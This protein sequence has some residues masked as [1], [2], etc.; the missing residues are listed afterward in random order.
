MGGVCRVG[1]SLLSAR[2]LGANAA[3]FAALS[4]LVVGGFPG[5]DPAAALEVS[6]PAFG[7][8]AEPVDPGPKTAPDLGLRI[9][10]ATAAARV[11]AAESGEPVEVEAARTD[12]NTYFVNPDGTQTAE[13]STVP[14]RVRADDG[15]WLDVD[16]TL[17]AQPDGTVATTATPTEVVLSG[18]GADT[19]LV[20]IAE[21]GE[22][23]SLGWPQ[24]LP[25]PVLDGATATYAEVLPGVDL[26]VEADL[27]GFSQFL[28]VK[29]PEAAAN[30]ELAEIDF[31]LE[32]SP[33]LEATDDAGGLMINGPDG[34]PAFT[35]PAPRMWESAPEP[36][37]MTGR[38]A[39]TT[40]GAVEAVT[41]P[42]PPSAEVVDRGEGED[43]AVMPI[44]VVDD[45]LTI[46][47]DQELLT[48]PETVFPVVIDPSATRFHQYWHMVWSN[49]MKFY[50]SSSEDA[51]VGYDGWSDG[52][53]SRVFYAIDYR[54]LSRGPQIL[55]ANFAHRQIHS[56]NHSCDLTTYGPGVQLWFT[57][58]IR[59]TQGWPGPAMRTHVATATRAHGHEDYCNNPVRT[60]WN[61]T[62]IATTAAA[63]GWTAFTLGLKSADEADRDGW[64]RFENITN[65]SQTRY[66]V[67]TVNYNWPPEKPTNL[68]TTTP[69]TVCDAGTTRPW[70]NDSTPIV[71]ANITEPDGTQNVQMV[72]DHRR[73]VA[74]VPWSEAGRSSFRDPG[75]IGVAMPTLVDGSYQW[76]VTATDGVGWSGWSAQTCEFS[77]DTVRPNQ[78]PTIISAQYPEE[79][80]AGGIG[81][82][83]TFTFGANTVA[84]VASYRYSL[85]S[86]ALNKTATPATIGGSKG[87]NIAPTEFGPNVLYAQS[88]DRAG[89]VSAVATYTFMVG[90]SDPI[91]V[92]QMNE[93][94]GTTVADQTGGS[95]TLTGPGHWGLDWRGTANPASSSL[96][97]GPG[98][99]GI[100][101]KG[102]ASTANSVL[103]GDL[104][105]YAVTAW[106][107]YGGVSLT[108]TGTF[109]EHGGQ[110]AY[111]FRVGTTSG[112][113]TLSAAR[114][115][116]AAPAVTTITNPTAT[117]GNRSGWTHV[118]VVHN[119]EA[120]TLTLYVD[121][122]Q[123]ASATNYTST[124]AFG[125]PMRL[126]TA[127]DG[128]VDDVRVYP[129]PLDAQS[130]QRIMNDSQGA[131]DLPEDVEAPDFTRTAS[132]T[133][134]SISPGVISDGTIQT[135]VRPAPV[136]PGA[137]TATVRLA[138]TPVPVAGLPVTVAALDEDGAVEAGTDLRVR[139]LDQ[140][141]VQGTELDGLLMQVAPAVAGTELTGDVRVSVDYSDFQNLGADY[142]SR[143]A[144]YQITP[145]DPAADPITICDLTIVESANDTDADTVTAKV[146][147]DGG[148]WF[149]AA[150][151]P[152]GPSGDY[153]ATSLAP[154]STWSAGG[155]AGGF[156]WNYPLRVPPTAGGMNPEL[157]IG[158]SSASVDGRTSSTNNQTSWI[159]EGHSLDPGFIERR[160]AGCAD[161]MGSGANNT[162]KTG[163][164][165]WKTDTVHLTLN[166][167]STEVILD[168]DGE[169]WR[170][171]NDDGSRVEHLTGGANGDNNGEYWRITT[172]DGTQYYFGM[173]KRDA[174][175]TAPTWS[176]FVVPVAGN[177]VGEPC[178]ATAFADS[179]CQ[180]A[181]RWNLAY[182]VDTDGNTITYSYQREDNRYSQNLD[183]VS[184]KYTRGGYLRMIEYGERHGSAH[185]T[186]APAKVDF[187]VAE[188]CLA[189]TGCAEADLTEGNA[190]RWP[191]VP[192][193]QM[194][195]STSTCTT[196]TS[197]TFFS[198]MRLVAV[199]TAVL[200]GGAYTEVDRWDLE[201]QF[202]SPGDG[203]SPALW[204]GRITHTGLAGST[205][206]ELPG[207]VFHGTQDANRVDGIDNA[208]PFNK[209]RMR[210]IRNESGGRISVN[211]STPEC[212]PS[213]VPS[214]PESNT[215][216]CFPVYYTPEGDDEPE[217]HWFHKYL[218]TSVV[219]DDQ[220]DSGVAQETHYSYEGEPAWAYQDS[221]LIPEDK[222][223]WGDWRGY[224][225]VVTTAGA[226]ELNREPITTETLYM[227]GM[228]G[229]HLPSGSRDVDVEDSEGATIED[230]K[231]LAG[232][233][234]ESITYDGEQIVSKAIHDPYLSAATADDGEQTAHILETARTRTFTAIVPDG[235]WRTTDTVMTYD[236][237][238]L[239]TQKNDRGDTSTTDDDL[240]TRTTY[241]RNTSLHIIDKPSRLETVSV[242]CSA[243][244]SRPGDVVTDQRFGYDGGAVG[245]V[246]TRGNATLNEELDSWSSGPVYIPRIRTTFDG[247]GR[248]TS[249]TD[250]LDRTT[251]TAYTNVSA[252]LTQKITTTNAAGH[253]STTTM[254][255]Y[256]GTPV[257]VLDA[258]EKTTTLQYDPLGRLLKV[259]G[260]D[261]ATSQTP[262]TEYVYSVRN[263]GVSSVA[264]KTLLPSGAQAIG[265]ELYDGWGRTRQVQ[266]PSAS[267]NEPGRLITDTEYDSRGLVVQVD[268]PYYNTGAPVAARFSPTLT[269]PAST[270][271]TYDGAGRTVM[272]AFY[273]NNT[274]QWRTTTDYRG[275]HTRV[276]PPDGDTPTAVFQDARG[277]V[278]RLLQYRGGSASGANDQTQY[279]YDHAGRLTWVRDP[280]HNEWTYEYD[281][282]GRQVEKNDPDTGTTQL[283]YDDAGQ[284]LTTTDAEGR[285][286][287]HTYDLL[288]RKTSNRQGSVTG[289]V[290]AEW[291]YDTLEL[292]QLTSSSRREGSAVYTEAVTGYDNGYRP[293]GTRVTIPSAEGT[294]IDGSYTFT[295]TYNPDGSV[296]RTTL[297]AIG[298][299]PAET[300]QNHYEP[301]GAVDWMYGY[302]TYAVDT[303]WSPYGEILRRGQGQYGTASWQTNTYETGTRRL[304][305]SR[306]DREDQS[307]HSDMNYAYDDAGN[308]TRM[309]DTPRNGT[310]DIQCFEYDYLR[311][312]TKAFTATDNGCDTPDLAPATGTSVKYFQ[313]YAYDLTGNRTSLTR[314][315]QS[316]TGTPTE[317]TTAYT[318]PTAGSAQPHTMRSAVTGST[319]TAFTYDD[320]GNTLT[321]GSESYTWDVEGRMATTTTP[322]GQSSFTYTA[323]GDRLVRRDP[324]SVTIYLPGH[325]LEL[326]TA[327]NAVTARR[328]YSFAGETIAVRSPAGGLQDLYA[329]H[330]D[331]SDIAVDADGGTVKNKER[332]P[333]GNYRGS[334]AHIANWPTD[335]GFH[336]GI[337]DPSTGLIQMGARVYDPEFGRFLSVDPIIDNG[338]PQQMN[339]YAYAN[340]SPITYSD[341]TGLF[342]S[343]QTGSRAATVGGTVAKDPPTPNKQ[344]GQLL[345]SGHSD[346]GG[347]GGGGGNNE[348]DDDDDDDCGW[349]PR[350]HARNAA[351]AVGDAARWAGDKTKDAVIGTANYVKD[352]AGDIARFVYAVTLKDLIDSCYA[353]FSL[354]GCIFSAFTTFTPMGRVAQGVRMGVNAI[355]AVDNVVDTSRA[356]DKVRTAAAGACSFAGATLV[357]MADGTRKAIEDI[358]IGDE[359]IA[360]DPE[361]GEQAAK[362]V[363]KVWVHEDTLVDLEV[364]GTTI[365]TTEDHPFWNASEQEFQ[366]AAAIDQGDSVLTADGRLLTVGGVD[367]ESA[368]EDLAYNLTVTDIH[369]YHVGEDDVLVHNTNGP[370]CHVGTN[371]ADV[372]RLR[373]QLLNE[374]AASAFT[375]AGTLSEG[376]LASSR[377]IIPG[378]EL[379]RK[380]PTRRL[381]NE[382]TADGSD[383]ADW[384]KYSTRTYQSPSGDFQ[385]HFYRNRATGNVNYNSDYKSVFNESR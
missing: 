382:L 181:W 160:Y 130:V 243:T 97:F 172:T 126:G 230:Q 134:S 140:A 335:R 312:L 240:C 177:H 317:T 275:D 302:N 193:D 13:L 267:A 370:G 377:R 168:E 18:G 164:L 51:R 70:V 192:F 103:R 352:H 347:G 288:G 60:E 316:S 239:M 150:A 83:G 48:D 29:T 350:C 245:V 154:S 304:L 169:T 139:G 59:S 16:T 255:T 144:L 104:P 264:T 365:T 246:P 158:Y 307:V 284:L 142:G 381:I 248:P 43:T 362:A 23:M 223:T 311:R 120:D 39:R 217:L 234:R 118:A 25:E 106:V 224:G 49:G 289:T 309:S 321:A 85:N 355:R 353:A 31:P 115:N 323:G 35:V 10:A 361:T 20:R 32:T 141:T 184:D 296:N 200:S 151:A 378:T 93:G 15:S 107:N 359:V 24:A 211:Y 8:V 206:V 371:A 244:P 95:N 82:A 233:V 286:V 148:G 149:A 19:P 252:G 282:R 117:V 170:P 108:P 38:L 342:P 236:S 75:S 176:T 125:G 380:D 356:A 358:A 69:V 376:A 67:L 297:P 360:T 208:P 61:A 294:A 241:V 179:F 202:P 175:D 47:P 185:T 343:D 163:D 291:T 209:W 213:N 227:R 250:T 305:R 283:T 280:A 293:L 123:A 375:D 147:V 166:G 204:L 319:S 339:G 258:N 17:V 40:N 84:D 100:P 278:E 205:S 281:L 331:T 50:N 41:E 277:R 364:D 276:D 66:P 313:E 63:E 99:V 111:A 320:T 155:S 274:E 346:H 334:T 197:P 373:N 68:R 44:E 269:I 366:D 265:Y 42:A 132:I 116:V 214:A 363:M 171:V 102:P 113:L 96:E 5:P 121:G 329:N 351:D 266:T 55:S 315:R 133:G 229:D 33:G 46:T 257:S 1:R 326:T 279:E 341:P 333:F 215:M 21:D 136:W 162:R 253:A 285:T 131:P 189:A 338:D 327:T 270:R 295:N 372:P 37:T 58:G 161:D 143:L 218:V 273:E 167:S 7:P 165:C 384:G 53:K 225:T 318:Y 34:E 216:N 54:G 237:Y 249:T 183:D 201:H 186:T 374:E 299:L 9:G 173:H 195:E 272:S 190:H 78:P 101:A 22:W 182:V 332:D 330:N 86:D 80:W 79:A 228:D 57:D 77:V 92:W 129:A 314:T 221:E 368:Y 109:L 271:T 159:G 76:R 12:R 328:Y 242:D 203:T 112:K 14:V 198:R 310:Q 344:P 146:S 369:T 196:R 222:R 210:S 36:V 349:D 73:M 354:G 235:G 26:V 348:D 178:R 74:N 114:S 322:S 254:T 94:S 90:S 174:A 157:A 122:V 30:P 110:N 219:T 231:Q 290:L 383:I 188:R 81:Q 247:Y 337:E 98:G 153:K 345:N 336:T 292:G 261:R 45:T 303:I 357:L 3:V 6:E 91:A 298:G 199:Q 72:V 11:A 194:C 385:V 137:A 135:P 180:Q 367:D 89:N 28:V 124:H 324:T 4:A 62:S 220:I 287:A 119:A 64:R 340:N 52:K 260:T 56:P 65:S 259:W 325:E 88:V 152:S 138:T 187:I 87:V 300:L 301:T 212:S 308:I 145:C 306:I 232:F 2:I 71:W 207:V 191:D 127:W 105:G 262:T 128:Y 268:G 27:S 263:N 156:N 379:G 238:G 226:G 251:T 256:H